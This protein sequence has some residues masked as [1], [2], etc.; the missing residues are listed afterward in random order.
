[1]RFGAGVYGIACEMVAMDLATLTG[2][3]RADRLKLVLIRPQ[4]SSA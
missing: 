2:Q 4:H 1:M 3:R